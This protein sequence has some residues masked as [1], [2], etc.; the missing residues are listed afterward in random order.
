MTQDLILRVSN[1]AGSTE[2]K[3]RIVIG[4][5]LALTPPMGWSSW[6]FLQA[7]GTDRELRAQADA[8][9]SSGLIDHGYAYI[10][11]DDGWSIKRSGVPGGIHP[12]D[13]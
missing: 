4:D 13:S 11:L 5:Q 9:V 7:E 2:R 8:M 3:F 6:D 12:R 10:N 1:S